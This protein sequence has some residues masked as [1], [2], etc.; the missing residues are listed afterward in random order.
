MDST[1]IVL[2][3]DHGMHIGQHGSWPKHTNMDIA[4]RI[5]FILSHP[6]MPPD[7]R[8]VMTD[9]LVESV[10][11]MPTILE[12]AGV[13]MPTTHPLEGVSLVPL[14]DTP[15]Q[16]WKTAV[17]SQYPKEVPMNSGN[18]YMGYAMRMP[19]NTTPGGTFWDEIRMAPVWRS[20]IGG[21]AGNGGEEP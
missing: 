13:P 6:D 17:F 16:A 10:D 19:A 9:A 4:T 14:M 18:W 5:P 15:H 1:I 3:G 2:W 8:G 20:V 21:P 7:T 12:L 11:I